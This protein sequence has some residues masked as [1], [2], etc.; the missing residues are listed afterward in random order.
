MTIR[1]GPLRQEDLRAVQLCQL[2]ML[3]E[4]DRICRKNGINYSMIAGTMLGAVRHG[5][6]IP[7]DD[8]AD[9]G[10][11]RNEYN[12]FRE[13]CKQDLDKSRFYFQDI[14]AT[15]GYRWGY[16]K[17]RRKGSFFLREGQSHMPY[18]T[19]IFIDI[20]PIDNVPDGRI[21]S[22]IYRF[23][24]FLIRKALWSEVGRFTE[25]NICVRAVYEA[26]SKIPLKSV[27]QNMLFYAD[28]I[29][30]N[31]TENVRFL[32][33]PEPD[34]ISEGKREWFLDTVDYNFEGAILRGVR[35]FD[36]YLTH[37][38]GDYMTLPPIEQRKTH[39]VSQYALP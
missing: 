19:G 24:C 20:F 36:S 18:S 6:Y 11:L 22:E 34:G 9:I 30:S 12:R 31:P 28:K 27:M 38:Y 21:Y 33:F 35:D 10:L 5:G 1:K 14:Q 25:K 23:Y 16:G 26:L 39:P 15:K 2:E 4:V 29:N 32:T 7:W 3:V 13:A 8:D 37:K 17:I